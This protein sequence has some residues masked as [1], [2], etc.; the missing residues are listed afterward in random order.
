MVGIIIEVFIH[1]YDPS[2]ISNTFFFN[3]I[4]V[5]LSPPFGL[6]LSRLNFDSYNRKQDI[7]ENIEFGEEEEMMK[8][9][10]EKIED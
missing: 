1:N 5:L 6:Y 10:E 2:Y 8:S 4:R 3:Q 7:P 9:Y